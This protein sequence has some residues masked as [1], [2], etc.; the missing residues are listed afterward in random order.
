MHRVFP[1]SKP[2]D[3]KHSQFFSLVVGGTQLRRSWYLSAIVRLQG[4]SSGS[5]AASP[6]RWSPKTVTTSSW[7]G[8]SKPGCGLCPSLG[9]KDVH[10]QCWGGECAELGSVSARAAARSFPQRSRGRAFAVRGA[11]S[12]RVSG[13]LVQVA[14][15][16]LPVPPSAA[17]AGRGFPADEIVGVARGLT[18]NSMAFCLSSPLEWGRGRGPYGTSIRPEVIAA[19]VRP[20]GAEVIVGRRRAIRRPSVAPQALRCGGCSYPRGRNRCSACNGTLSVGVCSLWLSGPEHVCIFGTEPC[21][22]LISSTRT[23]LSA[24]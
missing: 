6:H 10:H 21:F 15:A 17:A 9:F 8:R 1:P 4:F 7:V 19:A 11:G 14:S 18:S 20:L 23:R 16:P 3:G 2:L 5:P 12:C 13:S 24:N 22:F